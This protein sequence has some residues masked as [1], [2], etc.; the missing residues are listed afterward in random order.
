MRAFFAHAFA[1]WPPLP[2]P[3]RALPLPTLR[4]QTAT[5]DLPSRA[6]ATTLRCVRALFLPV[7]CRCLSVHSRVNERGGCCMRVQGAQA[8]GTPVSACSQWCAMLMIRKALVSEQGSSH[9]HSWRLPARARRQ[10]ARNAVLLAFLQ[11]AH[12]AFLGSDY[13]HGDRRRRRMD[14]DRWIG[15]MDGRVVA[16]AVCQECIHGP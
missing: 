13:G 11:G 2:R 16:V 14:R 5:A 1:V 8:S 12:G 4:G 6:S 9:S 3:R 10:V 15:R 7:S